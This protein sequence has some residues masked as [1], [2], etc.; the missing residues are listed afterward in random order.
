VDGGDADR[1]R[2]RAR[3]PIPSSALAPETRFH[4]CLVERTGRVRSGAMP[5]WARSRNR[6][7]WTRPMHLAM[8]AADSTL[9]P[10][11]FPATRE[12][13]RDEPTMQIIAPAAGTKFSQR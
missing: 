4:A 6:V 11:S 10:R 3:R 9:T 7:W 8:V 12:Q 1:V 13:R 2:R 5:A